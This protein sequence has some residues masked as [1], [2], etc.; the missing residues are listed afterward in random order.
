MRVFLDAN[1]ILDIF[2][3]NRPYSI[4]SREIYKY[5]LDQ[6]YYLFTSCDLFTTIYYVHAKQD[7][8]QAL[9]KIRALNKTLQVIEFS[10]KEVEQTCQLM[11]EDSDYVDL[12]DTLQYIM[13]KKEECD[14]IIS[15]DDNFVSKEIQL[16]TSKEFYEKYM[17]N[18]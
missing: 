7:K 2:D 6:K 9:L 16:I 13:A 12:E 4:F 5:L 11:L 15:N 17:E 10:N 18:K 8:D 14:L 1:I 3:P